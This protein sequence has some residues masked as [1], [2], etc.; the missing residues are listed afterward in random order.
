MCAVSV[1]AVG[2]GAV[3]FVAQQSMGLVDRQRKQ[4]SGHVYCLQAWPVD[5]DHWQVLV[6][7]PQTRYAWRLVVAEGYHAV[8]YHT[9]SG[10]V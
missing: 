8:Q 9:H 3:R 2:E 10:A 5:V 4:P 7:L 1:T 6:E